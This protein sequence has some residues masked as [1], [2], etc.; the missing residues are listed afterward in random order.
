MDFRYIISIL[1][2][3]VSRI[4]LNELYILDDVNNIRFNYYFG[5]FKTSLKLCLLG[6]RFIMFFL[7][8]LYLNIIKMKCIY[9]EM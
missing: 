7:Q 9:W 1:K 5:R 3:K 4:S 6:F 8:K 2:I